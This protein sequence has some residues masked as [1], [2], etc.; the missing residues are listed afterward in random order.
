MCIIAAQPTGFRTT[1]ETL[2]RCWNNNTNGG[3]FAYTDG[4]KVYAHKELQSF[5][6]YWQAYQIALELYPE[7]AFIHH[8]RIST[9]GKVNLDN[10]HPFLVNDSL[11]FAHNGIIHNAPLSPKFSDTYQFNE[12]ILKCLPD[13]FLNHRVYTDLIQSYI[14][15]GSKLAFLDTANSI[16][17]INESAGVWDEGIWY[18][19]RGYKAYSYHDYGGTQIVYPHQP[20]TQPKTQ[21]KQGIIFPP[22]KEVKVGYSKVDIDWNNRLKNDKKIESDVVQASERIIPNTNSKY[23]DFCCVCDE[24]L[25]TYL[26]RNNKYCRKCE[27]DYWSEQESWL[28]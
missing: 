13:G 26:E 27:K 17:I 28:F 10:C 18:S 2:Q 5:K 15:S 1:K 25:H 23:D 14:G 9:H 16:T 7:S 8:F 20:K 21:A 4:K 11:I 3:G 24:P 22:S 6:K 12:V 19:N